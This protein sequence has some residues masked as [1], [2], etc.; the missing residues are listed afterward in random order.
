[1]YFYVDESGQT[2]LNLFD[3]AQPYL[4]YGVLYCKTNIDILAKKV[5][6]GCRKKLG[7]ERLHAQELGNGRLV[8]ILDPILQLKKK[9]DFRFDLI[10]VNKVDHALICFFDQVFDQGINPAVPYFTY[11][12]PLRFV[13]LA[14]LSYLF[15]NPL[16]KKAW[17][18]RISTNNKKA[19]KLLI[20]V[21]KTVLSRV[22]KIPDERSRNIITDSLSWAILNPAKIQYNS[23]SKGDTLQISPNLIGFQ[24]VLHGIAGRI[25]NTKSKA[26]QVVVDRQAQFNAAQK[27]LQKMYHQ[28]QKRSNE[29]FQLGPGLPTMDLRHMPSVPIECKAGT[30]NIGLELVDI[31]IWVFKRWIE[32]KDLAPEL[33]EL[34]RGQMS[35]GSYNEISISALMDRWGKWFESLPDPTDS[36]ME[37]SIELLKEQEKRRQFSLK[38]L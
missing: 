23:L 1:M 36:Q 25:K 18:A 9:R 7:V 8:E 22:E 21:C 37:K 13:M 15:D 24:S 16:L 20:E 30:D 38:S 12:S 4:F 14:K 17:E 10:K 33:F 35:K 11:W 31:Y 34:I 27:L 29:P 6:K 5:I 32:K 26:I 28:A 2:G 3:E 19:E